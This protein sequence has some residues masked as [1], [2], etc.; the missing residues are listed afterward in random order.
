[1]RKRVIRED[2]QR[3]APWLDLDAIAQVEVTSEDPSHPIERALERGGDSSGWTAGTPGA[4]EIR[5]LFDQPARL[6]WIEVRFEEH[7]GARTQEFVLRWSPD[8]GRSYRDIVRQQYTFSP[9]GTTSEVE[10]YSVDLHD[11]TALELQVVPD[12]GNES[13]VASL[14]RLRLG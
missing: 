8:G 6:R 7:R 2:S 13:A 14:S 11:V 4:Q 3:Q 5:L 9:P 1:M 10:R 12:I